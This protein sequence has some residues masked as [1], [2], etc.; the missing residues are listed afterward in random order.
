MNQVLEEFD[1]EKQ[2]SLLR[3]LHTRLV[4]QDAAIFIAHDLNPRA[5]APRVKGF[6]QAQSWMQDLTPIS[7]S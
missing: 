7:L 6:V 5:L 4:D 3:R 1:E 2:S